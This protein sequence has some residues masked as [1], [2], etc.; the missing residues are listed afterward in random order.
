MI[1]VKIFGGLGNQLFCYAAAKALAEKTKMPLYVDLYSGFQKDFYKREPAL[2][3]FNVPIKRAG[4]LGSFKFPF[5][6]KLITLLRKLSIK[7]PF[8]KRFYY[9]ESDFSKVDTAFFSIQTKPFVYL[10]GYWQSEKYFEDIKEILKKEFV[11]TT[12]HSDENK[13]W[14]EKIKNENAVVVHARRLHGVPNEKNAK[15]RSDIRSLSL[16]YYS[17]SMDLI[18][19]KVENPHF[20]CFSDYPEW[21]KDNLK[22][23][24]NVTFVTHNQ[25][26]E[27]TTYEDFWLMSLCKHFIISNSTFSWWAAWLAENT[28]KIVIAPPLDI[29][30]NKEIVPKD[31]IIS[32]TI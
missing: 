31:W 1:I 2:T 4:T 12:P 9:F 10:D 14:A 21:F 25:Y 3:H 6:T 30:E 5:S 15:P 28:E 18:A 24:Y 8:I 13:T 23:S 17:K 26:G 32:T 7:H 29:W 16:D 11:L 22:T 20:Y 27:N 19:S